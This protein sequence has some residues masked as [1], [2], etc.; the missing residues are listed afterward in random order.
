MIR[1]RPVADD[2]QPAVTVLTSE[3]TATARVKMAAHLSLRTDRV[4]ERI[5]RSV[6]R[7][8]DRVGRL[9]AAETVT[10]AA[11]GALG[12]ANIYAA[13][14]RDLKDG[15]RLALTFADAVRPQVR[16]HLHPRGC[17]FF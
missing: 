1:C 10:S 11:A 6:R 15:T 3:K 8:R 7:T 5:A 2:H 4:G 12:F 14:A 17:S 13:F 9:Q 16:C